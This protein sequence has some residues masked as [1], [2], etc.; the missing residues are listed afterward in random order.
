MVALEVGLHLSPAALV[1]DLPSHHRA[2]VGLAGASGGEVALHAV[3]A[4]ADH[5]GD[6]IGP[7]VEHHH[8]HGLTAL[9]D[10][11]G[12]FFGVHGRAPVGMALHTENRMRPYFF[13][14]AKLF[15]KKNSGV[16]T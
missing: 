16:S 4:F 3:D 9:G 8:F 2:D 15:S 7:L 11:N 14:M 5:H 1:D 13:A 10:A 6:V 12:D